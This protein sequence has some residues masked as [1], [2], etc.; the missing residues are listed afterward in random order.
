MISS[1]RHALLVLLGTVV[2][3]T[4]GRCERQ[5]AMARE[6]LTKLQ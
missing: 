6:R 1:L 5:V 2:S 4:P 3:A